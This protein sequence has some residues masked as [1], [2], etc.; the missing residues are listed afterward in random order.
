MS[1]VQYMDLKAAIIDR[2]YAEEIDWAQSIR[3]VS[4]PMDFWTEYAWVVLNS[5]MKEQIARMIW[6]KVRP[7]VHG[8]GTASSVFGYRAKARGIDLVFTARHHL[9]R[10]YRATPDAEKMG[11]LRTLPFIGPITVFHLAKNYGFDC[12]KPD[13]HLVRIAGAEGTHALCARL[14]AATGD[15]IATVDL[16]IWRAANLGIV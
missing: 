4:D 13:R 10:T 16:V 14:A 12:A 15:R 6:E 1:P 9:L 2:G 8:G 7:V 5:G 3:P 11:W